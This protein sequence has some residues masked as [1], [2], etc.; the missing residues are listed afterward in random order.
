MPDDEVARRCGRTSEGGARRVL[1]QG[2]GL[3]NRRSDWHYLRR[4]ATKRTASR[5]SEV[6]LGHPTLGNMWVIFVKGLMGFSF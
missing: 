3:L 4:V 5:R 1:R 2:S 6:D